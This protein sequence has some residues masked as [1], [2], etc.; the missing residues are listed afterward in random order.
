MNNANSRTSGPKQKKCCLIEIW[1][2]LVREKWDK[3]LQDESQEYE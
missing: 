2:E 1:S 3:Y